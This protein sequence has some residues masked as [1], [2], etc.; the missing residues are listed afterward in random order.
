MKTQQL[1]NKRRGGLAMAWI[2]TLL[3]GVLG[4]AGTGKA[5]T[6]EKER[7]L[8][9]KLAY[10][11]DGGV[12]FL[13]IT[14]ETPVKGK[15]YEG[16]TVEVKTLQVVGAAILDR[17]LKQLIGKRVILQG[18][19]M[20]QQTIHHLTPLL[21]DTDRIVEIPTKKKPP[22]KDRPRQAETPKRPQAPTSPKETPKGTPRP[23]S[24]E[25]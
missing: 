21:W 8:E 16:K 4:L 6:G 19:P 25:W 20:Y 2:L 5:Q 24:V 3:L 7:S 13:T 12:K 15:N 9:G 22:E 18:S 17:N 23:T 11:T 1:E 10:A 14:A